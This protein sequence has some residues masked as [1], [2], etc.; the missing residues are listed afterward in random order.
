MNCQESVDD[1][2]SENHSSL[3]AVRSAA[4]CAYGALD[5]LDL[6]SRLKQVILHYY[7]DCS[8]HY[9]CLCYLVLWLV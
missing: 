8:L 5:V 7:I 3:P 2:N 4:K 6:V 1:K 9:I